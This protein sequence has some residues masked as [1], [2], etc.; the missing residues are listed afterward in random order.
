VETYWERV[1]VYL[2]TYGL[3]VLGAVIILVAGWILAGWLSKKVRHYGQKSKTIDKT[4]ESLFAKATRILVLLVTALAVLN[5]FG[6]QTASLVAVLGAAGLAVGLAWQGTL[7]DI[8]AG[9]MLLTMR[10]FN[11]GDSI[12]VDDI[13]GVV[14]EIGIVVTK[15]DSFNNMA[16][17]MPNSN[18]WGNNIKNMSVNPIRRLDLVVGFG[19]A[20]DIDKAINTV[21]SIMEEE[22]R[23]LKEPGPQIAISNLGDNSVEMIVRPWVRTEDYWSLK[24]DLTKEIKQRFDSEG[25]SLPFP[26]RDVH[27]IKD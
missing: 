1:I 24:F 16:I 22:Q 25:I 18:V 23:I 19:Y 12:E 11:V 8:A 27:I 26:Q 14:R 15:I 2:T 13:S 9:I 21:R 3:K 4:L 17:V 6:I 7:S 5:Q 20:D 10:P